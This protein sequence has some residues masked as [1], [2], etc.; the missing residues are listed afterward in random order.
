MGKNE[1]IK[2]DKKQVEEIKHEITQH[3][4]KYIDLKLKPVLKYFKKKKE[5]YEMSYL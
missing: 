5:F 2:L 1:V 3:I 4:E